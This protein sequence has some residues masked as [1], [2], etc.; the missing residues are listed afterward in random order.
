VDCRLRKWRQE[1]IDAIPVRHK[2]GF[3]KMIRVQSESFFILGSLLVTA[4]FVIF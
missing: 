3:E 4:V 1:A 2:R